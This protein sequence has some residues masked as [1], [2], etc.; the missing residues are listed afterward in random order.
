[1]IARHGKGDTNGVVL[2]AGFVH[3]DPRDSQLAN[4]AFAGLVD[5]GL[6]AGRPDDTAGLVVAY[7]DV[8]DS[9]VA[10]QRL[11]QPAGLP[12]NQGGRRPVA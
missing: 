12:L 7:S 3:S 10:T 1:M 11:Q 4:S 5:Q 9:L 6:I 8:S 2:M